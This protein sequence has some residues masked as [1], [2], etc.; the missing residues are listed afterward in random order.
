MPK[1]KKEHP[2]LFAT[3]EQINRLKLLSKNDSL[4][5]IYI[6]Q[7]LNKANILLNQTGNIKVI[8]R[9]D[10]LFFLG[11]AYHWTGDNRYAEKG[12]KLL[13]E[14]CNEQEWDWYHFLGT[15]ESSL[16]AGMGYDMFYNYMNEVTRRNVRKGLIGKGLNPGITAYTGAPY[17][18]F[19]KVRHNWNLVCNSGLLVG[20]LAIAGDDDCDFYTQTIVPNAVK[21][22]A[23][24]MNE[25][26]PDGAFPEGP[27]Y[28]GFATSY[29]ILGMEA[30]QN[31]LGSDFGLSKFEG[32]DKTYYYNWYATAP[33]GNLIS[34][35]DCSPD[36][37]NRPTGYLLWMAKQY[38]DPVL[39]NRE[40]GLLKNSGQS[41][42]VFDVLFYT[43]G[44]P[45]LK[46]E[47]PLDRYFRGP[48]ELA[49]LRT[50]WDKNALFVSLKAGYNQ[51]NHG[52]LDLGAFEL[53]ALGEKWFYDLGKDDYYLLDYFD[54]NG[55]RWNH[56]RTSS[57]SHNVPV[58]NDKNQNMYAHSHFTNQVLNKDVST[59]SVDLTE[60]YDDVCSQLTRTLTMDKPHKNVLIEDNYTLKKQG[61][62]CWRGITPAKISILGKQAI[63]EQKGK[64]IAVRIISPENAFFKIESAQQEKPQEA[65]EG[66]SILKV[67][68]NN[69]TG[70]VALKISVEPIK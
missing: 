50:G 39:A 70:N 27:G 45:A 31:A 46:T 42:H 6:S 61:N 69:Q 65:N 7:V 48:V 59:L 5:Q 47:M 51:V 13:L 30:M 35:A 37:E 10:N 29:T 36:T 43:P 38:N 32:F 66:V 19:A 26:A 56:F 21:S 17:G 1:I 28:W 55:G 68:A 4:L 67:I 44:D 49:T 34:Y 33:N 16:A 18:W 2:R 60:T 41:A 3:K 11:F 57:F 15:G 14:L 22:M 63:L 25:Y 64:K 53:F 62:I 12:V 52:H 8:K 24:A 20:A 40:H 54:M 9:M 23:L 58:I